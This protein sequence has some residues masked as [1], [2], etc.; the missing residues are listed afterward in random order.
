MAKLIVAFRSFSN[1]SKKPVVLCSVG[2]R[3]ALHRRS[4]GPLPCPGHKSIL[5]TNVKINHKTEGINTR[6]RINR[7]RNF[8]FAVPRIVILG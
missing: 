1:A 7:N 4:V 5:S 2:K 6:K 3:G 8:I